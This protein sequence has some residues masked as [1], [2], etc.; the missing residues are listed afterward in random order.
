[1]RSWSV[2]PR[3]APNP[4]YSSRASSLSVLG[5]AMYDGFDQYWHYQDYADTYVVTSDTARVVPKDRE[6][7]NLTS[8]E[9]FIVNRSLRTGLWGY[10]TGFI[11]PYANTAG[12]KRSRS[13]IFWHLKVWFT[14]RISESKG[15]SIKKAM[16]RVLEQLNRAFEVY[17]KFDWG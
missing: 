11:P 3:P 14:L 10:L 7:I 5:L 2:N 1:M 12:K 9:E 8:H 15:G 13:G 16:E 6:T 4:V 17:W